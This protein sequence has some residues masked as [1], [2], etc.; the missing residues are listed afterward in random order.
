MKKP[1]AVIFL[2]IWLVFGIYLLLPSPTVPGLPNS[3]KSKEPGD[4]VQVSNVAAYFNNYSREQVIDYYKK[5]FNKIPVDG[6]VFPSITLNH[7]PLYAQERIRDQIKVWYFEEI[8]H[9]FRE[10][11][12]IGGWTPALAQ[13]STGI[14]YAPIVYDLTYPPKVFYQKTTVRLMP[15]SIASR[16]SVYVLMTGA[17][18][19]CFVFGRK[20]IVAPV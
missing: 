13:L 16:L 17:I 3:I 12:Y 4:T 6:L 8:V 9:P 18:V 7:P 14:K 2:L 20:A 15:S 10:S 5:E 19:G 11:L 1:L